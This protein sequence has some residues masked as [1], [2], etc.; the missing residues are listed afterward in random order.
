MQEKLT[1]TW[2]L[3]LGS[4]YQTMLLNFICQV[5][6]G[7]FVLEFVIPIFNVSLIMFNFDY[8]LHVFGIMTCL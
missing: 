4:I 2:M 8:N 6:K 5:M 7:I 1:G 3:E